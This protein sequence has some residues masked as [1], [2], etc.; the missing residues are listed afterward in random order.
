MGVLYNRIA[1]MGEKP[2]AEMQRIVYLVVRHAGQV[3]S[4]SCHCSDY[5]VH[6]SPGCINW[7]TSWDLWALTSRP[8]RTSART[9]LTG[10]S[11]ALSCC[12]QYF[13]IKKWIAGPLVHGRGRLQCQLSSLCSVFQLVLIFHSTNLLFWFPLTALI[14]IFSRCKATKKH[15]LLNKTNLASKAG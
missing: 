12:G 14:S 10:K 2:S 6:I 15:T 4:A 3:L 5:D 8:Q 1:I 7:K 9:V 11:W 13:Y